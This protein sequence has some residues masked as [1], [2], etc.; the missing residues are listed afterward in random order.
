MLPRLP[1]VV[2]GKFHVAGVGVVGGVEAQRVVGNDI[3]HAGLVPPAAESEDA[4]G[5]AI[6]ERDTFESRALQK[7]L[8]F[9]AFRVQ[10]C[11]AAAVIKCGMQP[12]QSPRARAQILTWTDSR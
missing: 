5:I 9:D 8:G 12:Q 11:A 1:A 4:D 10:N 7:Q 3:V 2:V 6:N